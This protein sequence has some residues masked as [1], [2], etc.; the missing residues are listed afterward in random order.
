MDKMNIIR[1]R[2]FYIMVFMSLLFISYTD[3]I[4]PTNADDISHM[5]KKELN[6][7]IKE[8]LIKNPEIIIQSVEKFQLKQEKIASQYQNKALEKFITAAKVNENLPF[9]GNDNADIV[10]VEFSDYQCGYCKRAFPDLM[11]M[12]NDDGNIKVVFIETPIL[13]PMSNLAAK[14]ALAANKQRKYMDFH[15]ALMQSRGRLNNDKIFNIAAKLQLDM[16]K[17]KEYINSFEI[18]KS[19]A[20]N[21]KNVQ[22]LGINGTPAFIIGDQLFKGAMPRNDMEIAVKSHRSKIK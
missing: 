11:D 7:F 12:V 16:K 17:F 21:M 19:I 6:N 3:F 10:I 9:F 18:K 8:Y 4:P 20:S 14:A 1:S 22:I 2:V 15:R 5:S 13:G